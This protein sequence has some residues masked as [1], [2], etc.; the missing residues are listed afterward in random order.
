MKIKSNAPH[1]RF[2]DDSGEEYPDWN[3]EP[4]EAIFE[5]RAGGDIA[6]EHFRKKRDQSYR[7]PVFANTENMKGLQGYSDLYR[8]STHCI[9]VSGRGSLG[10]AHARFE[11][12]YPIVR[13]LVLYPTRD[14]CLTFFAFAINN[15]QIYNESTGV[16]Q[17]TAPQLRTYRIHVPHLA[18]QQ[19]IADFLS[20]VD[21]KIE[22]LEKKRSLLEKFKQ[23]L[24]QRLFSRELRFKDKHGQEFEEWKAELFTRVFKTVPVRKHQIPSSEIQGTGCVRVVDQ[25][26]ELIAGYSSDISKVFKTQEV[27]VYGDHTTVVK[28]VDFDFI[29]GADGTKVL[30][31]QNEHDR[32]KFLY[33]CLDHHNI[34]SEGYKRHFSILKKQVLPLPNPEE[35][36]KIADF[37][38]SVNE[39]IEL[40]NLQIEKARTFKHGLLQQLFV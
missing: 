11:K 5:I 22:Q 31:S 3:N 26:K 38:S 37:L 4:L 34:Q 39:K 35:Q 29:V 15:L 23:G 32:L 20:A 12:F 19:K 28:Y 33:Y 7:F 27:I 1:L 9:T 18:E 6:K 14:I 36:Q 8:V 25:G 2:K 40:V 10:I 24:M 17:L 30:L 13:L 16:P 21:E